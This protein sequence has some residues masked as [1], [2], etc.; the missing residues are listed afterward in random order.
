MNQIFDDSFE[1]SHQ[2]FFTHVIFSVSFFFYL[3]YVKHTQLAAKVIFVCLEALCARQRESKQN[4]IELEYRK[5]GTF[6]DLLKNKRIF[7]S[8]NF[9]A[10][11]HRQ[12][13]MRLMFMLNFV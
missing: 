10:K 9:S 6:Q 1:S 3:D 4:N 2:M 13:L 12:T 5:A 11:H 8:E 7:N